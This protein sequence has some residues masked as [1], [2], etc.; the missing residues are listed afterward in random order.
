MSQKIILQFFQPFSSPFV[1]FDAIDGDASQPCNTSIY[2]GNKLVAD[3]E[4]INWLILVLSSIFAVKPLV[5]G[6]WRRQALKK[7]A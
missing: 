1:I 2:F 3:I 7:S 5:Y 6:R 4:I